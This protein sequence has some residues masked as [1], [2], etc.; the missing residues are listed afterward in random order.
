MC[1]VDN[2]LNILCKLFYNV[3]I[4]NDDMTQKMRKLESENHFLIGELLFLTVEQHNL[5]DVKDD[6]SNRL[7]LYIY[8]DCS[9][10]DLL[11]SNYDFAV[12]CQVTARE[13][14]PVIFL[15]KISPYTAEGENLIRIIAP[16][17]KVGCID[18]H[19]LSRN[20]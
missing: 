3:E 4:F 12:Y 20:Y 17:G 16:N 1:F 9:H 15:S 8:Q 7:C 10:S 2:F 6:I 13:F 18:A 19:Y 5:P 11:N 14:T